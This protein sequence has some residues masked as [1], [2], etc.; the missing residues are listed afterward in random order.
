MSLNLRDLYKTSQDPKINDEERQENSR[1]ILEVYES[2]RGIEQ[3][4]DIL[5]N[6]GS[7]SLKLSAAV[8]L[9]RIAI[10]LT[11]EE[12]PD[13]A[14]ISILKR[15]IIQCLVTEESS[16]IKSLITYAAEP[17]VKL[18]Q[19]PWE[20]LMNFIM[21]FA[22]GTPDSCALDTAIMLMQVVIESSPKEMSLDF[23]NIFFQLFQLS[24][25]QDQFVLESL[26]MLKE[27]AV[28]VPEN[29]QNALAGVCE[30]IVRR[31]G[32]FEDYENSLQEAYVNTLSSIL[33]LPQPPIPI[34]QLL[35]SLLQYSLKSEELSNLLFTPIEIIVTSHFDAVSK[36]SKDIIATSITCA[37]RL[38]ENG[39]MIANLDIRYFCY[40][41]SEV[42]NRQKRGVNEL[43]ESIGDL[44]EG[45]VAAVALTLLYIDDPIRS[46]R[47]LEF[48]KYITDL[49]PVFFHEIAAMIIASIEEP[50]DPFYFPIIFTNI[51]CG[52]MEVVYE[53]LVALEHL[54]WEMNVQ[55]DIAKAVF[56]LLHALMSKRLELKFQ[57]Q[58]M[59]VI[60]SLIYS[61]KGEICKIVPTL[62]Q[63]LLGQV[64]Q[65]GDVFGESI[66]AISYMALYDPQYIPT[67]MK[68]IIDNGTSEDDFLRTFIIRSLL[69]LTEDQKIC[70]AIADFK[71][72]I[73][74]IVTFSILVEPENPE[75]CGDNDEAFSRTEAVRCLG[76]AVDLI[77]TIV[78]KCPVL[79]P[80]CHMQWYETSVVL[81][82]YIVTE[83]IISAANTAIDFILFY[84]QQG[85]SVEIEPFIEM[86]ASL[87]I[88]EDPDIS[89]TI[90][91]SISRLRAAH[92]D[93]QID[94]YL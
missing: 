75:A 86:C 23:S 63:F 39:T 4:V 9:R 40:I 12:D 88:D 37:S 89:N 6:D 11:K 74:E 22:D 21:T 70:K 35:V 69:V 36:F 65:K 90:K 44:N 71:E 13:A 49:E 52:N 48:L 55:T 58:I 19:G 57:K 92:L 68:L 15:A 93:I 47:L 61:T 26:G 77:H 2:D 53:C 41:A 5:Q 3:V 83:I 76:Y 54:L 43:I 18:E 62:P 31:F 66:Y 33:T 10:T 46:E 78:T 34:P 32:Q 25:E 79:L 67:I 8:G 1:S 84:Q 27:F 30:S 20:E 42:I 14:K 24:H 82:D 94:D 17:I 60:T 29:G 73:S 28:A 56:Q 91:E 51:Q 7:F 85:V 87:V 16:H 50:I 45:G 64:T 38:Y 72:N 80:S 59:E 81:M